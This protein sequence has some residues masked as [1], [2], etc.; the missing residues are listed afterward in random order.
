[1]A[2]AVGERI[3]E[4]VGKPFD[5]K[6]GRANIGASVGISLFPVEAHTAVELIKNADVAMYHAKESGRNN[7]KFYSGR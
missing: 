1:M 6:A 5:L 3:I 7:V 4:E 2:G